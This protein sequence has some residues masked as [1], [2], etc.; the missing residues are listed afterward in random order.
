MNP[1]VKSEIKKNIIS[2]IKSLISYTTLIDFGK[3][4][5]ITNLKVSTVRG[6]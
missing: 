6:R 2:K 3:L 4:K 1:V 5:N